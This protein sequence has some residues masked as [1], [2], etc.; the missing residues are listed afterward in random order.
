MALIS[1]FNTDLH[2]LLHIHL[3]NGKTQNKGYFR[4]FKPPKTASFSTIFK[5]I[6][7]KLALA[8]VI[9]YNTTK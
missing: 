1:S 5:I 4:V 8:P 9:C 2:I 6:H 3:N 7:L